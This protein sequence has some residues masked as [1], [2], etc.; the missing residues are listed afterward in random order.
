[1]V[2]TGPQNNGQVVLNFIVDIIDNYERKYP[3]IK[4]DDAMETCCVS[5]P[6]RGTCL[7]AFDPYNT[8]DTVPMVDCLSAK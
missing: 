8:A 5:C 2:F 1:M 6:S 4:F 7:Y 3:G